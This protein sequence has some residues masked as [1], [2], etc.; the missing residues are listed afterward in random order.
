MKQKLVP[1]QGCRGIFKIP[2]SIGKLKGLNAMAD[3]G[4]EVNLMPKSIYTRLTNLAP[5]LSRVKLSFANHSYEYPLGIAEDIV[6]NVDGFL[7]P[8][9]FVIVERQDEDTPIILGEPFLATARARLDYDRNTISFRK[10][11]QTQ[12]FPITPREEKSNT[13]K[14]RNDVDVDDTGTRVK[15]KILEWEARIKSYKEE[16]I[17]N[18]KRVD[19][20]PVESVKKIKSYGEFAEGDSVLLRYVGTKEPPD[21]PSTWWYGP[22]TIRNLS[23]KGMATVSSIRGG[24]IV[25]TVKRL[26]HY[27]AGDHNH[28]K[29]GYAVLFDD[30]VT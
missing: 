24:E 6:I 8:V 9:D 12:G 17:S 20:N 27:Q 5:F 15:E 18:Q 22:F 10:G 4:S 13:P 25:T 2:C 29:Q 28:I 14:G 3:Q 30:E 11:N 19:K 7:Y 23:E 26:R 16:E 1:K 21:K